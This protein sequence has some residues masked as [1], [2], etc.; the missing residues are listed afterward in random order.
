MAEVTTT[1]VVNFQVGGSG[2]GSV[3]TAEVDGRSDGFNGGKTTF[4]PGDSP[5]FL[6]FKTTNVTITS[7]TV[8]A[9]VV[10]PLGQGNFFVEQDLQFSNQDNVSLT[11]PINGSFQ[12]QKWLGNDLGA[13]TLIGETSV[14]AADAGGN[15]PGVNRVTYNSFYR[16]YR[17]SNVPFPLN[18]ETEFPVLAYIQGTTPG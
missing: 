12:T 9:G 6:I 17:I 8:S 15:N 13:L 1:L 3:L 4:G 11:K 16:A 14:K 10:T 7:V 18:G 5:V 2:S